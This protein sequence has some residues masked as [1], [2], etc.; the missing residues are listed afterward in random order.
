MENIIRWLKP[1]V[2][3]VVHKPS[4][5]LQ[6]KSGNYLGADTNKK[7]RSGGMADTPV[8]EAGP[9]GWR[10]KSSLRHQILEVNMTKMAYVEDEVK[11]IEFAKV[12]AKHFEE[13]PEHSSFGDI[14]P[15]GFLDLRW[16][17]GEDC[18]Y[19]LKIDET[20]IPTIYQ[21]IISR[22]KLDR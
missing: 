9:K 16:G 3:D 1:I 17:M 4:G 20:H 18:V 2:V 8:L 22:K 6:M 11:Q 5:M 12:A 21:Q 13:H 19:V 14:K 7:C 10:F 15:G